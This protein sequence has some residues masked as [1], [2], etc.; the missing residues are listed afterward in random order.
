MNDKKNKPHE[1]GVLLVEDG[2]EV[3]IR[4]KSGRRAR[5]IDCIEA[6]F[7]KK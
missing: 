3:S 4:E 1:R 5:E 6:R 2:Q 7:G